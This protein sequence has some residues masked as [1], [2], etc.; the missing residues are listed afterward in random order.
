M[1]LGKRRAGLTC[2]KKDLASA[3]MLASTRQCNQ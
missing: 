2:N 3:E 1:G